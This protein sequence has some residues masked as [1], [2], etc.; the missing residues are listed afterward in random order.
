M[1]KLVGV[2]A[3]C[4]FAVIGCNNK[5]EE[6]EKQISQ[7]R[8]EASSLQQTIAERDKY[9]EEVVQAVNDVYKD[10]EQARA[11]EAEV[12]ERTGGAEGPAQIAS[13]DTKQKLMSNLSAIN[14]TLIENRKRIA[15]LQAKVKSFGAEFASLT[16]LVENLKQTLQE[17]E[18]SIATLEA[19]I[20]GLESTVAE[21]T[22]VIQAKEEL[23][24]EQQK[25][26]NTAYYVVGTKDELEQKGIIKD[27]GGFLW[28]LLGSTTVMASDVDESL[29]TPIDKIKDETIHVGGAIREILPP[30]KQ[31]SFATAQP[32]KNTSDLTIL[33]P[34]KFWQDK[35]LVIVLK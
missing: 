29:F 28:G 24:S 2:V 14:S 18:R 25:I 10:L 35:Y 15:Q 32:D 23:I 31:E 20:Q 19:R 16:K 6:L 7:L 3:L 26:M 9:F 30:R 17:R 22:Q 1:K 12:V 33:S 13:A 34:Q 21:K 5:S 27:E 11:R 8:S 4:T